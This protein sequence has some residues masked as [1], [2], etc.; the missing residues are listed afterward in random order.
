MSFFPKALIL[1]F[2]MVASAN[3]AKPSAKPDWRAF[4]SGHRIYSSGYIDQP[5]VV[6]LKDGTWVC[7]FTTGAGLV[8]LNIEPFTPGPNLDIKADLYDGS[9]NLVATSDS[10][11][12]LDA[13]FSGRFL[14]IGTPPVPIASARSLE[15]HILPDEEMLIE[16]ILDWIQ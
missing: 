1:S 14:R 4:D 9:G 12:L 2:L 8:T 11:N 16:Q 5:Y 3:S 15:R 7:V 10:T 13:G 6:V